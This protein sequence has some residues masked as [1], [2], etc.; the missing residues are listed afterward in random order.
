MENSV[1]S[2]RTNQVT[3]IKIGMIKKQ[4]KK[5]RL[6]DGR[7]VKFNFKNWLKFSDLKWS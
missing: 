2:V 3:V 7:P 5:T 4:Q 1:T 6:W